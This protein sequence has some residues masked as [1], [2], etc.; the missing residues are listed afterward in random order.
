MLRSGISLTNQ[1][2]RT[3]YGVYKRVLGSYLGNL[4]R[5]VKVLSLLV[6]HR[7]PVQN[8][9]V[10]PKQFDLHNLLDLA[11]P[12]QVLLLEDELHQK[13]ALVVVKFIQDL[14]ML[15][16][17]VFSVDRLDMSKGFVQC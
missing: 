8:L 7:D 5:R 1:P 13:D 2:R 4:L 10:H 14:V 12:R 11:Y 15:L 16:K 3:K 9:L 17:C 6:I